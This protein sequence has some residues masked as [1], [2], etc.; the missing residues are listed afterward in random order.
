ML[1]ID[2]PVS[3]DEI[4]RIYLYKYSDPSVQVDIWTNK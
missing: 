4:E 1:Y 3:I 2:R